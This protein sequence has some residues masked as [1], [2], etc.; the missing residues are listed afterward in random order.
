[1][2]RGMTGRLVCIEC[3][4]ASD[5][6]A[7]HWRAYLVN[8]DDDGPDE[9]VCYCPACAAREFGSIWRRHDANER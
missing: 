9:V 7:R 8:S 1:M 5:V 4:L 6:Q 3:G 2:M